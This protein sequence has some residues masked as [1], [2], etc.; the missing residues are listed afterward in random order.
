MKVRLLGLAPLALLLASGAFAQDKVVNIYNW[1]DY[2]DPDMLTKFTDETGIK[3]VYDVFDNNE[4]VE[5]KLLAGQSGYDVVVPSA[6]NVARQ[7]QAGT[8]QKIDKSKLPNLSHIWPKIAKSLSV[9]DPGNEYAVNYMWGTTGIGYNVKMI[10]ERMADAPVDS[11][12][13]IFDPAVVSKFADC[14]VELLDTPE[15][16]M[17]AALNYLGLNPDSKDTDDLNKAGDLLLE[18]SAVHSPVPLVGLHRWARQRRYLHGG[19]L[20]R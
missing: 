18:D 10:T 20:Q 12:A 19:R 4:I 9:Y 2:I 14:G 1:S 7:I 15:E 6:P 17:P 16:L 13:M 11:W 5:T 3:V 8:L